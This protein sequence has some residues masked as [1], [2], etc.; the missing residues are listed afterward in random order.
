MCHLFIGPLL[1][2]CWRNPPLFDFFSTILLPFPSL[3]L[4]FVPS[5]ALCAPY[6]R[7]VHDIFP[8]SRVLLPSTSVLFSLGPSIS[9]VMT[10]SI[11]VR[12][13]SNQRMSSYTRCR[14][15]IS[16]LHYLRYLIVSE[17]ISLSYNLERVRAIAPWLA[18]RSHAGYFCVRHFLWRSRRTWQ[19]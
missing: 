11:K 15:K 2:L 10:T 3:L 8:F 6:I 7:H 12:L 1:N 19:L 5:F 14:V 18:E 4:S 13:P 16:M 9:W 17:K